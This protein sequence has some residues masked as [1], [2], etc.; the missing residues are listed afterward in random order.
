MFRH[1]AVAFT[2]RRRARNSISIGNSDT[3]HYTAMASN[4]LIVGW[5]AW[6]AWRLVAWLGLRGSVFIAVILAVALAVW[7]MTAKSLIQTALIFSLLPILFKVLDAVSSASPAAG[8]GE[9][10]ILA[11]GVHVPSDAPPGF[12]PHRQR[13]G[14]HRTGYNPADDPRHNHALDPLTGRIRDD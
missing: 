3:M 12:D 4:L 11:G 7:P 5:L 6:R 10:R 2:Q 8:A 1:K 14:G 13:P 9:A